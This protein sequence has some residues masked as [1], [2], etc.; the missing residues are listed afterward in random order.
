MLDYL[1]A[2]ETGNE[3]LLAGLKATDF[4]ASQF[5]NSILENFLG[6]AYRFGMFHA[7]LHPANLIILPANSVGYID[8]GITGVL[9]RYSRQ[10]V[11][12]LTLALGRGDLDG[13]CAAFFKIST[14]NSQSDVEGFRA[15]MKLLANDWYAS[16]GKKHRLVM[17]AT[18]VM[19]DMLKL[20]HRTGIYPER[21]VVKYIRSAIAIDGLITRLAPEFD[22]GRHL[23]LICNR[24]LKWHMRRAMLTY[25]TMFGW[26]SSSGRLAQDG[27]FR[28]SGVLDRLA[29]GEMPAAAE[30][31]NTGDV[32]EG[33]LWRRALR[34]AVLVFVVSIVIVATDGSAKLGIN[35]F[36]AAVMFVSTA[37][38]ML[39]GTIRKLA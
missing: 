38:M 20:S 26:V 28:A 8:F 30:I 23:E 25:N 16:Q 9:S 15:G 4:N 2:L 33:D 24:H 22:L 21:D 6:D 12:A 18:L 31:K 10:N 36:T 14:L 1:R 37:V 5:V 3:P 35:V 39:M 34:L 17:N 19:L 13:M 7:D 29:R 32:I 11:V 27:I